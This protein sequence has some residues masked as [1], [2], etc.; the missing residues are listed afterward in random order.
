M[1]TP[2]LTDENQFPSESIIFSHIGPSKNLWESIFG[3]IHTNHPDFIEEWRYYKDGKSWLLKVT[4]KSK[5]IFW[6]TIIK[7]SFRITFYFGDKAEPAIRESALSDDLKNSFL[8][9]KRFGKIRG[10]TVKIN[11]NS[12]VTSVKTLI[13]IKL[14][15]K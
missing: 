7:N 5:T 1:E 3:H 9:G 11:S 12:D 8:N 2:I 14:S 4:K 13:L 10:I 6:L 15:I